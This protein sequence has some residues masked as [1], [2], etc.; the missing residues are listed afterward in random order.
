MV[1]LK[2]QNT[3]VKHYTLNKSGDLKLFINLKSNQSIFKPK[4]Q[5]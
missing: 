5:E 2:L 1:K 3:T 4:Q